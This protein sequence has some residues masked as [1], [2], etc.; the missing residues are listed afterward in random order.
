MR[1]F[2][3]MTTMASKAW[4][5]LRLFRLGGPALCNVAATN[6]YNAK[7]DF[8]NFANGKVPLRG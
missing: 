7:C 4:H 5:I 8:C 6:A 1:Q 2:S 3:D